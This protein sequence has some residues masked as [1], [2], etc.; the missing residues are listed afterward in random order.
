MAAGV[1]FRALLRI[2]QHRIGGSDFLEARLG[3]R[4]LVAV[5]MVFQGEVAEGIL[6]RLRIGVPR[7]AQDLIVVA[8]LVGRDGGIPSEN[9]YPQ[10]A[11]DLRK[12]RFK[13]PA[14]L[15]MLNGF[16]CVH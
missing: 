1:V 6:D 12:S 7:N 16:F 2:G 4:R 5:R 8:L 14:I 13:T 11:A 15:L 3:F 9:Q 10:M